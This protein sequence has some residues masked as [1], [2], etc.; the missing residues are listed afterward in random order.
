MHVT[1]KIQHI[2][3]DAFTIPTAS[4]ESDGTHE[5]HQTTL[6]VAHATGGGHTGFGYTYAAPAAAQVIRDSLA[7]RVCGADLLTPRATYETLV[8]AVR[9]MG[10]PGVASAAIAAVD[11][12]LHDLKARF[13]GI[14]LVLLSGAP[15]RDILVYGSGGFTSYSL[16]ELR[17]QLGGWV[18]EG[19]PAV[20]MKVGSQ[21]VERAR[22][23]RDAAGTAELY[24][25]ANGA[26]ERKQALRFAETVGDL[27]VTWFEEPVSSDDLQGLRL[28]RDRAPAGMAIAAGEYG[29]DVHYFRRMLECGAVDVLQI[30]GTRAAGLPDFW[31]PLRCRK[32]LTS[33][34][35]RTRR[36][37]YTVISAA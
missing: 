24:V 32:H 22:A 16:E 25:D 1:E 26:Y 20:K 19:I 10:R 37:R 23:A 9:N 14:P 18:S 7:G 3:I 11:V 36:P 13:L 21:D 4:P 12:A 35:Q 5:W 27:G 30:D 2:A 17:Q 6:V 29:Y 8:R 34:F 33:R 15:K 28:L 31:M